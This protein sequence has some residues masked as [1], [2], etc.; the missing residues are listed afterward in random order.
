MLK[1][2]KNGPV[3]PVMVHVDMSGKEVADEAVLFTLAGIEA[4]LR[5]RT[6]ELVGDDID[7][8]APVVA[9]KGAQ[10]RHND[11]V[12]VIEQ[13]CYGGGYRSHQ[14]NS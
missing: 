4:K 14:S 6:L 7:L 9:H 13:G 2:N 1:D 10:T 8:S 12:V 5:R 3:R 11:G